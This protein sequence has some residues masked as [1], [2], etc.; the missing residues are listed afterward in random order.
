MGLELRLGP[1]F[2]SFPLFA[3]HSPFFTLYFPL[4]CYYPF[5][6]IVF[7]FTLLLSFSHYCSHLCVVAF[8]FT[9]LGFPHHATTLLFQV[10]GFCVIIF[11]FVL[12]CF[13]L[14]VV[15]GVLLFIKES[16]TNPMH[17]FL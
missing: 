1:N 13:P 3:F 5:R 7:L 17:S 15:V 8:I 2:S 4:R 16:C 14:H 6:L 9:L 11:L 10:Q 12:L